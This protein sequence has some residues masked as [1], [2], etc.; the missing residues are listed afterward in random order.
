MVVN[1][2]EARAQLSKLVD[3]AYHG[4]AVTIARNNLP[5]VD[6]VPHKPS[7]KRSLGLLRGR[8]TVPDD[9]NAASDVTDGA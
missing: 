5:V 7:G 2:S 8:L 4:H 1:L 3:M 6:L 9:F